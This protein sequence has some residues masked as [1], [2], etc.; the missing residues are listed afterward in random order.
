MNRNLIRFL[1]PLALCVIAMPAMA[2]DITGTLLGTV[3]NKKGEPIEGALV[4]VTGKTLMQK[5]TVATNARGEFRI[6]LLPPGEFSISASKDGFFASKSIAM[7]P[8]GGTVQV[9]VTLT[10]VEVTSAIVEVIAVAGTQDKTDVKTQTSFSAEKL[11]QLPRAN[12]DITAIA[13]LSPGVTAGIGGRIQLRGGQTFDTKLTLN[14]TEINDNVFGTNAG[15]RNYYVDD[16]I[17]ETQVITSPINARYGNFSGGI[18]NAITKSGGNDFTGSLRVAEMARTG[19]N[20]MPPLGDWRKTETGD[21]NNLRPRNADNLN[22]SW[23]LWIGGPIV[24]DRVWFSLSTKLD[25]PQVST[26]SFATVPAG[27]YADYYGLVKNAAG[28]R[29]PFDAGPNSGLTYIYTVSTQFY[30]TKLTFALAPGHN[31]ELSGSNAT[32]LQ[33]P[34]NYANTVMYSAL[35]PQENVNRY[36]ALAYTGIITNTLTFEAHFAK[37]H[38]SLIGGGDPAN[39]PRLQAADSNGT[40][41]EVANAIFMGGPAGA[42]NRDIQTANANLT[43]FSPST[44]MGQHAIEAGFEWSKRNRMARNA[45]SP[46]D[47]LF[48]TAGRYLLTPGDQSTAR[49]VMLDAV[50]DPY[51]YNDVALYFTGAGATRT[52]IKSL[53]ANDTWTITD[54]WQAMVGLRYDETKMADT[55]GQPKIK[56]SALSPRFQ[57]T[58]DPTGTQRWVYKAS[59]ARY[60][61][62]LSDGFTNRFSMAG[63]PASE[64]YASKINKLD[65]TFAD[66]TNLANYD[67]SPAGLLSFSNPAS[68]RFVQPGLK[69][70]GTDESTLELRYNSEDGSWIKLTAVDRRW[71]N[72][73]DR[74]QTLQDTINAPSITFP[75][76]TVPALREYWQNVTNVKRNYKS[77]ELEWNNRFTREFSMGG[78][79]TYSVLTGNADGEGSNPPVINTVINNQ[80]DVHDQKGRSVDYYAPMG[81]L[82]TDI[83]Y[84]VRMWATYAAQ[85]ASGVSFATTLLLNYDAASPQSETR[86]L[87]FEGQELAG[88]MYNSTATKLFGNTYTRFYGSRGYYRGNDTYGFDLRLNLE[89]PIYAKTKFFTEV[90]VFNVF[91]QWMVT[92]LS[93]A[94]NTGSTLRTTDPLAGGMLPTGLQPVVAA[95][96]NVNMYGWGTYGY[97]SQTGGRRL[98]LSAGLRW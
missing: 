35:A 45:Q 57:L 40:Y 32:T 37:K 74:I 83:P 48:Q 8:L 51:Q 50:Q 54:R 46:T 4:E 15:V 89:V 16:A 33:D 30:E 81:Y 60:V 86:T 41:W 39:G 79:V 28:Q 5:R 13:L 72:M 53:Y 11:D 42:D 31:L 43:W 47:T 44:S 22:R 21:N 67:I 25:P 80:A 97:G 91:N 64:W 3:R 17:A 38:Q 29:L 70:T 10:T 2:Q 84:R 36:W 69:A 34:R 56:S 12:K 49:Y 88:A 6:P 24:K 93:K 77:L 18:V 62:A 76:I 7:L 61:G 66:A 71:S 92:G 1:S 27:R 73:F 26:P 90:T 19:W 78:N 52:D 75:T 65:A 87:F 63:N 95:G 55:F 9:P 68:T 85:S 14:G 23:S 94:G 58:W 82:S 98:N 96:G 59:W 20:A